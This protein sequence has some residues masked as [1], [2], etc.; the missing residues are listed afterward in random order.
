MEL[1]VIEEVEIVGKKRIRTKAKVD[2]GAHRTSIDMNLAAKA[3]LG[4]IIKVVKVK[5]GLHGTVKRRVVVPLTI[6]IRGKRIKTEA[7]V[8]D[9]SHMKYKVIIGRNT[10]KGFKVRI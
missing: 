10:L 7:S 2:T 3:Q 5:S 4:P 8:E 1:N 6:V 9:R